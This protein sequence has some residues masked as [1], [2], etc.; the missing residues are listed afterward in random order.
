MVK[1]LASGKP[2]HGYSKLVHRQENWKQFTKRVSGMLSGST[3]EQRLSA[4]ELSRTHPEMQSLIASLNR[5]DEFLVTIK[6][7]VEGK[8]S[9]IVSIESCWTST[10]Q[11]S[12]FT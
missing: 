11:L 4:A 3:T 5:E 2:Y 7:Q 6:T 9:I 10:K 1:K 8:E 12:L